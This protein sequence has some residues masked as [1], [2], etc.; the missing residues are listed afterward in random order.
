VRLDHLLSREIRVSAI[1]EVGAL[2]ALRLI[3]RSFM[4][5][6]QVGRAGS[7]KAAGDRSRP[8]K[9]TENPFEHPIREFLP[10]FM[11]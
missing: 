6:R 10:L 11:C 1:G 4:F 9:N 7:R 3:A 8:G 2:K 5:L